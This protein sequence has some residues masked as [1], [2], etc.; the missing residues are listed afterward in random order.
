M[1][2][3]MQISVKSLIICRH[4]APYSLVDHGYF[5]VRFKEFC[6]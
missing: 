3:I 1:N 4:G 2:D 5:G 6:S